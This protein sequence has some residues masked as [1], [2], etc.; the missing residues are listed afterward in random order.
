MDTVCDIQ[1][2]PIPEYSGWIPFHKKVGK[3]DVYLV[4]DA[5]CHVKV[6]TIGGLVTG[7]RGALGVAEAILNDGN[8][9]TL[10]KLRIELE[11]HRLLRKILSGFSQDDYVRLLGLL[12]RPAKRILGY[13]T[14]DETPQLL[15]NAVFRQPRLLML[16]VKGLLRSKGKK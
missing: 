1:N 9:P 13:L 7:F 2:G 11:S 15:I 16:A 5:A 4:G 6:S 14:R 12:N 10:T 3:S 8:S